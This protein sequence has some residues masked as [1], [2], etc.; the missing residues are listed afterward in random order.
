MFAIQCKYW[1]LLFNV[2]EFVC[3]AKKW[4]NGIRPTE[5]RFW[6]T[7]GWIKQWDITFK[8]M[9]CLIAWLNSTEFKQKTCKKKLKLKLFYFVSKR[10]NKTNRI[11]LGCASHQKSQT[12]RWMVDW[13]KEKTKEKERMKKERKKLIYDQQNSSSLLL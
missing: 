12:D 9:I 4:P 10:L 2:L 13:F 5:C 6:M 3:F 11:K 8:N 7:I 1:M